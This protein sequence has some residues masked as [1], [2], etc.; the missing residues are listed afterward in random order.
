MSAVGQPER[1]TQ[2]RIIARFRDEPTAPLIALTFAI[3]PEVF[4]HPSR[5]IS[6]ADA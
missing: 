6:E 3:R 1:A 2:S 5:A 4:A